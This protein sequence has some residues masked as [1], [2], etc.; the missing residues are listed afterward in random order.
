MSLVPRLFRRAASDPTGAGAPSTSLTLTSTPLPARATPCPGQPDRAQVVVLDG[1][2]V[3]G[4]AHYRAWSVEL[5]GHGFT[6][7]RTGALAARQAAQAELA[8]LLCAQE[9][10]LLRLDA[11]LPTL[12]HRR[13]SS[14]RL[15]R[16]ADDG[17]V[18]AAAIDELGFGERWRLDAGMLADICSAT[19]RSRARLATTDGAVSGFLI[20]GRSARIG[21]LQ[22]LAVDPAAR[23]R[24]VATTLI[25]DA[26][27]WMRRTGVQQVYVNTHVD[28]DGALA[29]YHHLGFRDLAERLRVYEGDLVR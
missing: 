1:G 2:A 5:A 20:S 22:R 7:I 16:L 17:Y 23:R 4:V 10:V 24:N 8:G 26:F 21:Y 18:R 12:D 29:L 11:P 13:T 19:P 15:H 28:N 14:N 3:P 6:G 27:V 25:A 9:L